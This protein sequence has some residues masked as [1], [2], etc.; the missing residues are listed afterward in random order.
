MSNNS[1]LPQQQNQ[2][3]MLLPQTQQPTQ[4]QH[5]QHQHRQQQ[6][7]Q[8]H[9]RNHSQHS[10]SSLEAE[11]YSLKQ[12]GINMDPTYNMTQPYQ[13]AT[14]NNTTNHMQDAQNLSSIMLPTNPSDSFLF[15]LSDLSFSTPYNN[16][17]PVMSN[18]D[19]IPITS[20]N[21][22][23]QEQQAIIDQTVFRNRPDNP[24]WSVPSSIELDDWTAYLLPQQPTGTNSVQNSQQ[25]GWNSGWV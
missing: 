22:Y 2:Q 3:H 17:T 12:F 15:G 9:Q 13:T 24:F 23:L 7:Q 25:C 21:N 1:W 10:Q 14:N 19:P 16:P 18:F 11:P 20:N 4:H 6:Q 5:H 8:P